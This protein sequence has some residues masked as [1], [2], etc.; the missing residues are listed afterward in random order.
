MIDF[1]FL[2]ISNACQDGEGLRAGGGGVDTGSSEILRF[3]LYCENDY[4][5]NLI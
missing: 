1:Y 5:Y 4:A 3:L 2:N